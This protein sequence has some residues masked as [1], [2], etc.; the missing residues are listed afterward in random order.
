MCGAVHPVSRT[1]LWRAH[2][3]M[4]LWNARSVLRGALPRLHESSKET[5]V[6]LLV[7]IKY[8]CQ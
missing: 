5:L 4:Y 3:Q 1:V 2:G 8:P 7:Q 6:Y